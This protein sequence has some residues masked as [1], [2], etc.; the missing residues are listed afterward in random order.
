MYGSS[1]SRGEKKEAK[2]KQEIIQH[3]I[4]RV[5]RAIQRAASAL[6]AELT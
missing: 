6:K 4:W 5:A 1:T 3:E 2:K